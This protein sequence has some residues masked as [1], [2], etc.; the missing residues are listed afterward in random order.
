MKEISL[1]FNKNKAAINTLILVVIIQD[2]L[3]IQYKSDLITFTI[4]GLSI[5]FFKFYKFTSKTIFVLCSIPVS[6]IF[7]RFLIDPASLVIEKASIWLFL[8]MGTGII[9]EIINTDA[10]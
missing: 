2:M 10:E 5:I 3:L 8:L 1:F 6:I 4:L 7:F 9:W